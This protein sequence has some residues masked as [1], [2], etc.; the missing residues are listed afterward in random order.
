MAQKQTTFWQTYKFMNPTTKQIDEKDMYC[1]RR[2]ETN[3]CGGV[4]KSAT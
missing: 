3:V 4:Y 2:N 1:E